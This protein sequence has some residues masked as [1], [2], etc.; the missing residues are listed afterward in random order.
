MQERR[1]KQGNKSPYLL[2]P[3][4]MANLGSVDIYLSQRAVAAI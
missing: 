3:Y 4:E 2:T 1:E